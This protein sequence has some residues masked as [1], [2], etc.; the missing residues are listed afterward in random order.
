MSN[1]HEAIE[2][3]LVDKIASLKKYKIKE[4]SIE[5]L[6]KKCG[7]KNDNNFQAICEWKV[8]INNIHFIGRLANYKYFNMDM[9]IMN[10]LDYFNNIFI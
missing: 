1:I 2:I 4:F 10:A 6:Y 9:A 7:F 8:A 3:I 5:H